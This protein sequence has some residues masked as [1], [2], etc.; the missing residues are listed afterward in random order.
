MAAD[1]V[2]KA[3]AIITMDEANPRAE[4]VTIDTA[5]GTIVAVGTLVECQGAAP[6]VAVTDLGDTVL[7][8]GFIEAHSHPMASGVATEPPAYWISDSQGYATYAD[9]QALW[10][11]IDAELPAGQP[12]LCWGLDRLVQGAPELTNTDLD[13]FFPQRPA[14]VMD[15]SGHEAYFNSAV[16]AGNGWPD[17]KPP[18]DPPA[19]SF[20][21]NADGTSNGRAYETGAIGIAVVTVQKAAIPNPLLSVAK[22]FRTLA[23]AGITMSSDHSYFASTLKGY[24]ALASSADVPLRV[25][26]YQVATE[27]DCAAPLGSSVDEA[28]LWKAGIKIWADGTTFIGT[29]AASFPFLDN[30]TTKAA[31]IPL[32]PGAE[33]MMNYTR[34]QLDALLDEL[35]DS[36]LQIATHA[37]GDV[38]ID[39]ALDAYAEALAHHGLLGTDHRWRIEHWSAGRADQFRRAKDLGIMTPLAAYQFMRLGDL[40]DGTLY[41]SDIGSQWVAVADAIKAGNRIS[42]HSDSPVAPA[43]PLLDVQCM[44]SRRTTNGNLHG[45]NQAISVDEAFRAHTIDAAYHLR[46]DHDLGSI[47]VG[48]LADFVE[49]SADPY[50][51]DVAHLTEHVKV[52]GTWSGGRKIDLDTFMSDIEQIDPSAHTDLHKQ[53]HHT[54]R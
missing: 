35:A 33:K 5:T 19:A 1:L 53:A 24:E 29:L 36:G 37:H 52:Q 6:G 3:S 12:V 26:L 44:A 31:Q 18:E 15:I 7:M 43:D 47:E 23:Q 13:G 39:T 54:C 48:K 11:K 27:K 34:A 21:R 41:P 2:L 40:L 30:A 22:W 51:V 10:H 46:R 32:G 28:R 4:A 17:S 42:F 25:G 20:G 9:V 50:A 49:L 14:V 45:A 38:A 8:P 16:I